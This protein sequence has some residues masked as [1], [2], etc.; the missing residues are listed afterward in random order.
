[1]VTPPRAPGEQVRDE[2]GQLG[3]VGEG[4]GVPQVGDRE[5]AVAL[6]VEQ[7]GHSRR[8]GGR[9]VDLA[10]ADEDDGPR[11]SW[12]AA[13]ASIRGSGFNTA[14]LRRRSSR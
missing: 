3:E 6:G 2:A 5:Q 8:L 11:A 10:V 14:R 12:S 7:E 9:G 1:M 4:G 13:C